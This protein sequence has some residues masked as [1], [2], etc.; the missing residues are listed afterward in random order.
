MPDLRDQ[1][2]S[3]YRQ[4]HAAMFRAQRDADDCGCCQACG[5]YYPNMLVH[6]GGAAYCHGCA[7]DACKAAAWDDVVGEV[8]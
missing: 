8:S 3:A 6:A 2:V 7:G 4:H 1:L 5:T